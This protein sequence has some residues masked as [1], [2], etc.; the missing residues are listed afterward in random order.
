MSDFTIRKCTENDLS[1]IASIENDVFSDPWKEAMLTSVLTDTNQT[2]LCLEADGDVTAYLIG[3]SVA[4]ESEVLRVAVKPT[5]R[6]C[7]FG[8]ALMESFISERKCA[9]DYS[10]FLEVRASNI[11]AISL[12]E[13]CG[14]KSY[15]VRRNYY[16]S[17]TEDAVMMN[18]EL[19]N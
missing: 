13:S 1:V 9:K 8:H 19:G 17:P 3:C 11:S 6:R 16:K 18:L 2:M 14:F 7:G 12:Y 10:I 15:A 4:G 5:S